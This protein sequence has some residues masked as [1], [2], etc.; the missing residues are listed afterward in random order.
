MEGILTCEH[1]SRSVPERLEELFRPHQARLES[2]EGWDM[3][4]RRYA[5]LLAK[6]VSAP[7]VLATHS[8]LVVDTNRS[9]T[10]PRL[11]S[12]LTRALPDDVKEDLLASFY[13]PFRSEVRSLVAA[14][15]SPVIHLSCHSFS[16]VWDGVE[17]RTDIGILYDPS[18][19][20]ERSFA[21]I[22]IRALQGVDGSLV[23]HRNQ[24]YRG[25]SDGHTAALRRRV[26]QEHYRGIEIEVNQRLLRPER[27]ESTMEALSAAV[28]SA[29]AS[30]CG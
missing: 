4:A 5:E 18:R 16:P 30:L 27:A 11:F 29:W 17:R 23:V 13:R 7:L 1:A 12:D 3:G 22:L 14:A 19:E 26:P 6:T 28:E 8:R 10:H 2:H 21:A 24:P 25:T 15:R 9:E 20:S